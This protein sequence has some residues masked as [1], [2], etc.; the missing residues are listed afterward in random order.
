MTVKSEGQR[1]SSTLSK[2]DRIPSTWLIQI[3]TAGHGLMYQYLD[4]FSRVVSTFLE[5]VR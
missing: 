5:T 2:G 4:Q 3:R 1:N